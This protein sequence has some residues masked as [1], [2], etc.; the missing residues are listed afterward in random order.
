MISL[1]VIQVSIQ[2]SF[3]KVHVLHPDIVTSKDCI[4]CL[5]CFFRQTPQKKCQDE[6]YNT[7]IVS[8]AV[9]N[10][11]PLDIKEFKCYAPQFLGKTTFGSI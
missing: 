9:E 11:N 5:M 6:K 4:L 2:G 8:E 10:G 7:D 3:Y 1:T